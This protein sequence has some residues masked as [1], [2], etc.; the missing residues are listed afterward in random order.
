LFILTKWSSLQ[1]ASANLHTKKV[2]RSA[3]GVDLIKILWSKFQQDRPFHCYCQ[4]C[5]SVNL[6][7]VK[8]QKD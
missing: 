8:L 2:L 7:M 3:P 6:K 1:T 5:V 4:Q